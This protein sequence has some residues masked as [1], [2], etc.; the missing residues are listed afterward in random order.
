MPETGNA[1]EVSVCSE[2]VADKNNIGVRVGIAV[3]DT[4]ISSCAVGVD[5]TLLQEANITMTNNEKTIILLVIFIVILPMMSF[6]QTP[7][8]LRYPQVGGMRQR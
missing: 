7:N 4:A 3:F 6:N 2:G 8:G 5:I 1:V